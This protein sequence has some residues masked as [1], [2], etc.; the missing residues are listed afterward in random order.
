MNHLPAAL[1]SFRKLRYINELPSKV[2]GRD[3]P[4]G[5]RA[6]MKL[7]DRE[8]W[9]QL[10]SVASVSALSLADV[11]QVVADG[12]HFGDTRSAAKSAVGSAQAAA[13]V[14]ISRVLQFS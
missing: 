10:Q 6:M 3:D 7:A 4:R 11:I 5:Y 8:V 9:S 2:N 12:L 1:I 14:H 13:A